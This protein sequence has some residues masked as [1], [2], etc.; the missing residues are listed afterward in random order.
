MCIDHLSQFVDILGEGVNFLG[1]FVDLMHKTERFLVNLVVGV[2]EFTGDL[3]GPSGGNQQYGP[4]KRGQTAQHEIQ[5]DEGVGVESV[6]VVDDHP[7]R[8]KGQGGEDECPTSHSV[9]HHI[10]SPFAQC[11]LIIGPDVGVLC[12][13]DSRTDAL[14]R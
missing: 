4:L 2:G 3:I 9:A 11:Q 8:E 12:P 14:G 5:Q 7:R 13:S 1:Q 10:G 6:M